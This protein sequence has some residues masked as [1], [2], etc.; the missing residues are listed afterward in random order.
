[1]HPRPKAPAQTLDELPVPHEGKA[2]FQASPSTLANMPAILFINGCSEDARGSLY[3]GDNTAGPVKFKLSFDFG[4]RGNASIRLRVN[5]STDGRTSLHDTEAEGYFYANI[6]WYPGVVVSRPNE[7]PRYEIDFARCY[8]LSDQDDVKDAV[9]DGIIEPEPLPKQFRNLDAD[10]RDRLVLLNFRVY[11][12]RVDSMMTNPANGMLAGVGKD[13]E[14]R[15]ILQAIFADDHP[16]IT[17]AFLLPPVYSKDREV[18]FTP[19][20]HFALVDWPDFKKKFL[21]P[22]NRP[23]PFEPYFD[24][25]G[26]I[27]V[28]LDMPSIN[29]FA[30]RMLSNFSLAQRNV[31]I[32]QSERGEVVTW[33]VPAG[34][35]EKYPYNSNSSSVEQ[36][37][38]PHMVS[39]ARQYQFEKNEMD[40]IASMELRFTVFKPSRPAPR[41]VSKTFQ[42]RKAETSFYAVLH[43]SPELKD[44]LP[45]ENST[46]QFKWKKFYPGGSIYKVPEEERWMGTVREMTPEERQITGGVCLFVCTRPPNGQKVRTKNSLSHCEVNGSE[47]AVISRV[48]DDTTYVRQL[49]ALKSFADERRTDLSAVRNLFV[50]SIEMF[51]PAPSGT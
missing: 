21:T 1:M 37:V 40:K 41:N 8:A 16:E 48:I 18:N 20:P 35:F 46:W 25:D 45:S 38:I 30:N 9:D 12:G 13:Q 47:I 7:I 23:K 32:A 51:V 36:F 29:F 49:D 22:D 26:N 39:L 14:L 34:G 43:A 5:K 15:A 17:A 42:Q 3:E 50:F 11:H 19:G 24:A 44:R 4:A 10:E 27:D 33:P 6:T 31:M 28:T 2:M